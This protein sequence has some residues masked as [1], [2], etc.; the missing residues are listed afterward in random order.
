MQVYPR[1]VEAEANGMIR[2]MDLVRLLLLWMSDN[3]QQDGRNWVSP[4]NPEEMGMPNYSMKEIDY[5]IGLLI[6]GGFVDGR[7]NL[8]TGACAVSRLTWK[9]HELMDDIRS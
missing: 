2:D 9:G 5:H 6:N 4:S 1:V 7:E 8:A 3:P